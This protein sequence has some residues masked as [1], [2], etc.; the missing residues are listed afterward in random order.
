[1]KLEKEFIICPNCKKANDAYILKSKRVET[2]KGETLKV[3]GVG[4]ANFC[5]FCGYDFTK[6]HRE[7]EECGFIDWIDV[8]T[9]K[10]PICEMFEKTEDENKKRRGEK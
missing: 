9:G 3:S 2:R 6:M 5:T 10:C 7:C 8:F 4:V 1:M